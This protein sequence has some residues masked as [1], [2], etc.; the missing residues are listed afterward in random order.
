MSGYGVQMQGRDEF[1][2]MVRQSKIR[3]YVRQAYSQKL[4]NLHRRIMKPSTYNCAIHGKLS[5]VPQKQE[6]MSRIM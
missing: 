6:P 1:H 3:R 5:V 2:F 4:K